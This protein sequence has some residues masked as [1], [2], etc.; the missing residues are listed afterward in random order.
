MKSNNIKTSDL[1]ILFKKIIEEYNYHM[2][3]KIEISDLDY[4]WS[5]D[6]Q[7]S[8]NIETDPEKLFLFQLSDDIL[9]L[10]R[11]KNK[12]CEYPV[13]YDLL[14]LS[15]ILKAMYIKSIGFW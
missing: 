10:S 13:S 1:E 14:R 12:K 15:A 8:F 11:L 6:A 4:Y 3:G 2:D 5:L 9:E 7:D